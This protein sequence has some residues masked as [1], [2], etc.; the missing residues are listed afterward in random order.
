M[1]SLFIEKNDL[2]F[3]KYNTYLDDFINFELIV[4][5]FSKFEQTNKTLNIYD[6]TERIKFNERSLDYQEIF[7]NEFAI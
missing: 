4:I 2:I 6:G 5:P 3:P 1:S 7:L